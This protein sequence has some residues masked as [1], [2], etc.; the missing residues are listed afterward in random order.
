MEQ[1]VSSFS[2]VF[3]IPH[4]CFLYIWMICVYLPLPHAGAVCNQR[5]RRLMKRQLYI[6]F[7]FLSVAAS[8][9][10]NDYK[11]SP[12]ECAWKKVGA[13]G[14]SSGQVDFTTLALDPAGEPYVAYSD[15]INQGKATVMKFDGI[16]GTAVVNSAFSPGAVAH[17]SLSI[18]LA[19][20]HP[21]VA[22]E[23]SANSNSITVMHY[24]GSSWVVTGNTGFS[25]G[26]ATSTK[27][28]FSP[29]GEP[30]VSFEDHAI[31]QKVTV[32]KFN[33]A[34][35]EN[36]G[37]AGFSAGLANYVCAAFGPTGKLYTAYQDYGNLQK[38]TVMEFNGTDW[39][40]TGLP[41]FST[42]KAI[43][44]SHAVSPGGEPDVAFSDE[45]NELPLLH[46]AM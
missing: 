4:L 46:P 38:A 17:T 11:T 15:S 45:P 10:R 36:V 23:D 28:L 19:N 32:M 2:P 35:W 44:L 20:G 7:F 9:Q 25:T 22:F 39:V 5:N 3:H 33:G 14:F 26:K 37:S 1:T 16:N 18:S 40:N 34:L 13:A 21:Y 30:V 31:L 29:V 41:G 8:A 42:G 27:L 12:F 24:D 6:L 43:C